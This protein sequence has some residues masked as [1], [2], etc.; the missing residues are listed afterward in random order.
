MT[1]ELSAV[2]P[3]RNEARHI[4]G[5]V[6]ALVAALSAER[7]THEVLVVD[8]GSSDGTR[9]V[10]VRLAAELPTVRVVAND[11]PHGFGFAVRTG[12]AHFTGEACVLVMADASDSPHDLV[13]FYRT[14]QQGY[15]CVFGSQ[16]IDGGSAE[17]YPRLKWICNRVGNRLIQSC[18]RIRYDDVTNAFKMYRR[19]VIAHVQPL[20]S[21]HFEIALELPLKAIAGGYRYAVVPNRWTSRKAGRSKFQLMDLGR[22]LRVAL[23]CL[24]ERRRR[25]AGDPAGGY[26]L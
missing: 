2:V 13:H 18:F 16:F 17:G 4:E 6:R 8:D 7:I 23:G 1:I 15:D 22:Y 9:E 5:T 26:T 24:L 10:A 14:L 3:A 12:L 11:E 19:C 25:P 21:G 20:G